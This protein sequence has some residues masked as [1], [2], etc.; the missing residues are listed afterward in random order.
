MWLTKLTLCVVFLKFQ[1]SK[2]QVDE[3]EDTPQDL[4][5]VLNS[6][7]VF[8]TFL[9]MVLGSNLLDDVALEEEEATIFVPTEEAIE[10]TTAG[11]SLSPSQILSIL[12][13]H[14]ILGQAL[15]ELQLVDG[16]TLVSALDGQTVNVEKED[17][18]D[19][20]IDEI[21]IVGSTNEVEL[22]EEQ[23]QVLYETGVIH[24]ITGVLLPP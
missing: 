11:L 23:D 10:E 3:L 22:D 17:T 21:T 4:V 19:D 8:T 20:G 12:K 15:T 6:S 16:S 14:I 1:V 18:D 13:Y 24:I 9:D 5:T 2:C 7:D